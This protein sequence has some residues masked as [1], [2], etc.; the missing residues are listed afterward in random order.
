MH[1]YKITYAYDA[2]NRLRAVKYSD[3]KHQVYTYDPA[4][5]IIAVD[6]DAGLKTVQ[7]ELTLTD[8]PRQKFCTKCGE[9][10]KPNKHFC[11]QCGT[12]IKGKEVNR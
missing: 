12:P 6:P 5:N 8:Q 3:G 4:G 2:L 11:T 9:N 7:D 1:N 10:I